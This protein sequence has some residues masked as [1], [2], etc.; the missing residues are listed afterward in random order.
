MWT[1]GGGR[2]HSHYDV[3]NERNRHCISETVFFV[4]SCKWLFH[5]TDFKKLTPFMEC[6]GR[7]TVSS[8]VYSREYN[9]HSKV[10]NIHHHLCLFRTKVHSYKTSSETTTL[11]NRTILPKD[12][13]QYK[14]S[15]FWSHNVLTRDKSEMCGRLSQL[16]WLSNAQ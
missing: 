13:R 14:T 12:I 2:G 10:H 11:T 16:S 4:S 1:G 7:P 5:D 8:V 15:L 3:H 9:E 6:S